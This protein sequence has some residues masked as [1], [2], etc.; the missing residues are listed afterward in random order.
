MPKVSVVIPVY[1][2]EKYIFQALESLRTQSFTDW[3]AIIVDDGSPDASAEIC[4]DFCN[5]DS[6]FKLVHQNNAGLSAA[7]NTGMRYAA[8]EY[9]CFFDSDDYLKP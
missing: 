7:R 5:R 8:G 4:S 2:V 1:K 3:E 6:R 9:I